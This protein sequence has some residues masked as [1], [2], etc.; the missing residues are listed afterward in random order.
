MGVEVRGLCDSVEL[1]LTP[2]AISLSRGDWVESSM[3]TCWEEIAQ[4]TQSPRFDIH[5]SEFSRSANMY[6]R[7]SKFTTFL[8]QLTD[9]A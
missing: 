2:P 7:F 6:D 9:R 1:D 8:A 4:H 5:H 3:V